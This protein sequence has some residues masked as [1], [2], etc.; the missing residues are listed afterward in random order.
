MFKFL[1][2]KKIITSILA[3]TIFAAMSFGADTPFFVSA[4]CKPVSDAGWTPMKT[5]LENPDAKAVYDFCKAFNEL[6]VASD[7]SRDSM[8]SFFDTAVEKFGINREAIEKAVKETILASDKQIVVIGNYSFGRYFVFTKEGSEFF[9]SLPPADQKKLAYAMNEK[10]LLC[11]FARGDFVGN[12][13]EFKIQISKADLTNSKIL[14]A[15][16][17]NVADCNSYKRNPVL[18]EFMDNN[19]I[20]EIEYIN[21]IMSYSTG[22]GQYSKDYQTIFLNKFLSTKTKAEKV[23]LIEAEIEGLLPKFDPDNTEQNKWLT[24]LRITKTIYAE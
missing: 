2:M 16:F 12:M 7:F 3:I 23:K 6:G 13:T 5:N 17:F 11:G 4:T 24:K 8:Y 1:K 20:S 21:A 9:N 19:G 22:Q 10:P 15:L 18:K 14:N